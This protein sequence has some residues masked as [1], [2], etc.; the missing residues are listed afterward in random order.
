MSADNTQNFVA[1]YN[2]SINLGEFSVRGFYN[3]SYPKDI[4]FIF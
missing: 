2:K 4:D 3:V 1:A